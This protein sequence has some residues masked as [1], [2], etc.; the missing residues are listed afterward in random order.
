MH[1]S[2]LYTAGS[3]HPHPATAGSEHPAWLYTILNDCSPRHKLVDYVTPSPHLVL[4]LQ[5]PVAVALAR[6]HTPIRVS[7]DDATT[8]ITLN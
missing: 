2:Q 1:N 5:T 8:P 3:E 7:A 6:Q 4:E